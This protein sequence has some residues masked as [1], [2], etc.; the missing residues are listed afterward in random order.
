MLVDPLFFHGCQLHS[1]KRAPLLIGIIV[2]R[3]TNEEYTDKEYKHQKSTVT[4]GAL[5]VPYYTKLN[6]PV[7][8][9]HRK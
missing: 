2:T 7:S 1:E 5:K 6:V 9:L 3:V 4:G 8:E